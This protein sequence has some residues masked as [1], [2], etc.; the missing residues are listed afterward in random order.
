VGHPELALEAAVAAFRADGDLASYRRVRELSR[1]GWPEYRERLLDHLRGNVPYFPRGHVEV[2]LHEGLI[3]D[4]IAAVEESPTDALLE[5]VADA[6]IE[7]HPG[8]VIRT[9]RARAEEIMDSGASKYYDEAVR[10][11]A[12]ARDAYLSDGRDEEWRA[13]LD[14]LIG[15]HQRKYK[16]RPMLE[17]LGEQ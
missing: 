2:F 14:E 10:W 5:E 6:A 4:A 1:E 15:I 8:W 12:K 17:S 3:R 7:S 11:L 16:L 13:Y 9:C